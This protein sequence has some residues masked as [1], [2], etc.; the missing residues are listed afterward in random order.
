MDFDTIWDTLNYRKNSALVTELP[1]KIILVNS[2]AEKT[3]WLT[4]SVNGTLY[5]FHGCDCEK[6]KFHVKVLSFAG[7]DDVQ[8]AYKNLMLLQK[9][10]EKLSLV[11]IH[12]I[13]EV[14]DQVWMLII[15]SEY[16][17][18]LTLAELD[19]NIENLSVPKEIGVFT[20]IKLL[21]IIENAHEEGIVLNILPDTVLLIRQESEIN[22]VFSS[23]DYNYAVKIVTNKQIMSYGKTKHEYLS[24]SKRNCPET[25]N[26]GAAIC[27]YVFYGNTRLC[28]L[29]C[30]KD[31]DEKERGKMMNINDPAVNQIIGFAMKLTKFSEVLGNFIV[32]IWKLFSLQSWEA[33]EE[34]K[35]KDITPLLTILHFDSNK[36]VVTA[37]KKT[38]KIALD[39]AN[40]VVKV[41]NFCDFFVDFLIIAKRIDFAKE[42]YLMNGLLLILKGKTISTK[43]KQG[44]ISIGL[45]GIIEE[46]V[47]INANSDLIS[48]ISTE[49]FQNNT[50]TLLQVLW[51]SDFIQKILEK[52]VKSRAETEF[53]TSTMSYYGPHSLKLIHKLHDQLEMSKIRTLQSIYE[54][55][56]HHKLH[57]IDFFS[58]IISSILKKNSKCEDLP[59]IIKTLIL[60]IAEVICLPGFLQI[61]HMQ[62]DCSNNS[63]HP[64]LTYF[65]KNPLMVNC[66]TC[67][68]KYCVMCYEKFHMKHETNFLLQES[69]MFRCH[70]NVLCGNF[71]CY[72]FELPVYIAP[73]DFG[74]IF[75]SPYEAKDNGVVVS[76]G[77]ITLYSLSGINGTGE[78]EAYFEVYVKKPGK[79]EN[80]VVGLNGTGV[81]YYACT[82]NIFRNGHFVSTGPRF[83]SYD[84]IGVGLYRQQVFFTLNG[85]L[86]RPMI[87][88]CPFHPIRAM[89]SMNG[90][91]TEIQVKFNNWI[92]KTISE[93]Y[94]KSEN[95]NKI[96]D[97]M[98]RKIKKFSSKKDSRYADLFEKFF[99]LMKILK[100]NEIIEK[101]Q[102]IKG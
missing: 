51:D 9:S 49:F 66:V 27:L 68:Y 55:P 50:L 40:E 73:F 2:F 44:L 15:V 17:E 5:T 101:L 93:D 62:G 90:G 97:W 100:K 64:L 67:N 78:V 23:Y 65:G 63:T 33:V 25:E 6:K 83:G 46:A 48:A 84:T 18:G 76:A 58:P 20:Y 30:L 4:H 47:N 59:E 102:K 61:Q 69:S 1:N 32:K 82:G 31:L 60:I 14:F 88:C 85:L 36:Y 34:F 7:F 80:L 11:R 10:A 35:V 13:F 29:P 98:L 53:L 75:G 77:Y 42:P 45:L 38:L 70:T 21:E 52:P 12:D 92:F 19:E 94:P 95:I 71:N 37:A 96:I 43:L 26:W 57:K 22:S 8:S 16:I 3:Y 54:V 86:L 39:H 28:E 24:A 81:S 91:Y 99:E 79:Y 41:L 56:Y 74:D 87:S 72:K 89:V